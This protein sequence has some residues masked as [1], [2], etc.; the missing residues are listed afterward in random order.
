VALIVSVATALASSACGGGSSDES[1][2][3]GG[4]GSG[5]EK[6]TLTLRMTA[7]AYG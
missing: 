1:G 3:K 4:N 5:G 6:D 2:S 7:D